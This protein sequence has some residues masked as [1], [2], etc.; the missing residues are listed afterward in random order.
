MSGGGD[1][2]RNMMPPYVTE[3]K[4]PVG[5]RV[6]SA[7]TMADFLDNDLETPE[8]IRNTPDYASSTLPNKENQK[9]WKHQNGIAGQKTSQP[10]R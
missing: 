9:L 2:V 8:I 4:S 7:I 6:T 5:V 1:S 10:A 3:C